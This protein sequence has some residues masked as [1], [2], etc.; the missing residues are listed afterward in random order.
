MYRN[1][2]SLLKAFY[3]A[4][5][6]CSQ[7]LSMWLYRVFGSTLSSCC[8]AQN[9]YP[10]F[11]KKAQHQI[12]WHWLKRR[13]YDDIP[14]FLCLLFLFTVYKIFDDDFF[15]ISCYFFL[16]FFWFCR[17]YAKIQNKTVLC[18]IFGYPKTRTIIKW[19]PNNQQRK[20]K[21]KTKYDKSPFEKSSQKNAHK[22]HIILTIGTH[23]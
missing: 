19:T 13:A 17:D 3:V 18:P 6:L 12:H 14:P 1:S 7:C 10:S 15:L 5:G 16:C 23:A 2:I 20:E 22:P 4:V 21:K 11:A 8:C 9:A